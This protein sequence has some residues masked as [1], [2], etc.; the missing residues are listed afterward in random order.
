MRNFTLVSLLALSCTVVSSGCSDLVVG[1]RMLPP[2]GQES[3]GAAGDASDADPQVPLST[4]CDFNAPMPRAEPHGDCDEDGWCWEDPVPTGAHTRVASLPGAKQLWLWSDRGL[5][6]LLDGKW[7]MH[8]P[9]TKLN[10]T[11]AVVLAPDDIWITLEAYLDPK[12]ASYLYHFDGSQWTEIKKSAELLSGLR[13]GPEGALWATASGEHVPNYDRV[14]RFDGNAWQSVD[15][16]TSPDG[17]YG[18]LDIR[19]LDADEAWV[20]R[21]TGL[22]HVTAG[23]WVRIDAPASV[24]LTAFNVL[25]DGSIFVAGWGSPAPG[26]ALLFRLIDDQL[27]LQAT[28]GMEQINALTGTNPADL[29]L[30]TSSGISHFDGQQ[31]TSTHEEPLRTAKELVATDENNLFALMMGPSTNSGVIL[32]WDGSSWND[33]DKLMPMIS[34]VW[35][36]ANDDIWAGGNGRFHFDGKEWRKTDDSRHIAIWG[37]ASDN[38]YAL[39]NSGS[40]QHYDGQGWA[41]VIDGTAFGKTAQFYGHDSLSGDAANSLWI[42]ANGVWHYDGTQLS[43]VSDD[44]GA[45]SVH[46]FTAKDVW[47]STNTDLLHYDGAEWHSLSVP[48]LHVWGTSSQDLWIVEDPQHSEPYFVSHFDGAN[49]TKYRPQASPYSYPPQYG[50]NRSQL[51]GCDNYFWITESDRVNLFDGKQWSTIMRDGPSNG[52]IWGKSPDALVVVGEYGGVNRRA[53]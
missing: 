22:E 9:P 35:G 26:S 24:R 1:K 49:W 21:D 34:T 7:V 51:G 27:V 15:E 20:L 45:A 29:W 33:G 30:A 31:L 13:A 42:A 53:P 39:G 2:E 23:D 52:A 5:H 44:V 6:Q 12:Y 11:G 37:T 36:S 10:L 41:Q 19:P 28:P 25:S 47:V 43:R 38:V 3:A 14:E 48:A 40:I 50:Q 46:A 8:V 17:D 18:V 32:H 4:A 16:R